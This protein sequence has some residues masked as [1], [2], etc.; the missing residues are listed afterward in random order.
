MDTESNK[1]TSSS[2]DK[3]YVNCSRCDYRYPYYY[4]LCPMCEQKN[5]VR[6]LMEYKEE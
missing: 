1:K 5:Y 6:I 3:D 2:D 4:A